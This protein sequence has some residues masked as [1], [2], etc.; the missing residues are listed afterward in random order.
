MLSINRPY[1]CDSILT[2]GAPGRLILTAAPPDG[3]ATNDPT[4]ALTAQAD[5][6]T[7]SASI[8]LRWPQVIVGSNQKNNYFLLVWKKI[9]SFLGTAT[10]FFFTWNLCKIGENVGGKIQNFK[11][12]GYTCISFSP[13]LLNFTGIHYFIQHYYVEWTTILYLGGKDE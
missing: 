7:A 1:P 8:P 13:F 9:M 5:C 12:N 3:R 10:N 6:A 2:D 4:G 11:I